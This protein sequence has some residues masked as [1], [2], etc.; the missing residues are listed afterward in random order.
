[1]V[2][3]PPPTSKIRSSN[4]IKGKVDKVLL[5]P[6]KTL[7]NIL[8][9]FRLFIS[10]EV[11]AQI[12][13]YTNQETERVYANQ[14]IKW[15]ALDND[16]LLSFFGL[17][18]TAGHMKSN[19]QNYRLFWDRLYGIT[20]FKASMSSRRFEELLR[21]IR[22]DDKLTRSS[23]RP[24]D[25]L[26]P[27]RN[28]WDMVNHNLGKYYMPSEYLVGD[29]QL[30]PCRSRCCFIQYLPSKPEKY[31]I[32]IW[33]LCDSKNAYP[34]RGIPDTGKEGNTR[35]VGLAKNVVERLCEPYYGT[36]RNITMDNYFT[37]KELA[38]NLLGKGLTIVGTLRKNKA[39]IPEFLPNRK[40]AVSSTIFGF[41][42][43][44]TIASHVPK[45]GKAVIF[46]STMHHTCNILK[47]GEKN[48][49]EIN[50]FY[51]ET[52]GGVD[53]FDQL[54]HEYMTKRKTN[55]WPLAFFMNMLDAA[56]VAAYI[57]WTK[58]NS[59]WNSG[60]SNRRHLFLRELCEQLV[61]P[62]ILKRQKKPHMR[63]ET[64]SAIS[65]ILQIR[66]DVLPV[67]SN[68]NNNKRKR[69][70]ICPSKKARMQKQCCK[71]CNK[72]VCY[73]HSQTTKICQN[74]ENNK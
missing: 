15:K 62:M 48:I 27:I 32:Q 14:S 29:E 35:S 42:K 56:G 16:E 13:Q 44:I 71:I 50:M 72:N 49:S 68:D 60:K 74:C 30:M 10:N 23:R 37:S 57:I 6:G 8:D 63:M 31:G 9:C 2:E 18:M 7:E 12:I 1:M 33:W 45:V 36:N 21:F 39:C 24:G 17:L 26:A 3:S 70:Y 34:L 41:Q 67:S 22:F 58:Q 46:L 69:C 73:E 47:N 53:T 54:V 20:I 65:D 28:I 19:N 25:K 40:R 66:N 43:N 38:E 59:L 55:R 64:Q 11:C 4:K 52:K 5:P 51:N 61:E